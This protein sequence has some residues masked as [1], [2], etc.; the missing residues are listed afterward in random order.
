[1]VPFIRH[2]RVGLGMMGEQGAESIHARFNTLQR[3]YANMVNKLDRLRCMVM[4]HF[5]QISPEN[6]AR[7]PTS[8]KRLKTSEE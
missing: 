3:T 4:E 6:M 5:R 8:A 2:W 1:M 7:L